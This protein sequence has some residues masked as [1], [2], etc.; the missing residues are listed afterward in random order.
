MIISILWFVEGGPI[1]HRLTRCRFC[2]DSRR[3][4]VT[5][6]VRS[7]SL[8]TIGNWLS[9]ENNNSEK[10]KFV[11]LL[12]IFNVSVHHTNEYIYH[13]VGHIL[14]HDKEHSSTR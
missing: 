13:Y 10:Y 14:Q 12:I 4:V 8:S 9:A 1:P 6:N 7:D 2:A 3:D 5:D 11:N